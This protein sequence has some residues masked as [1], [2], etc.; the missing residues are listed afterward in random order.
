[1][2]K[3]VRAA[4]RQLDYMPADYGLCL[5]HISVTAQQHHLWLSTF[6]T[7]VRTTHTLSGPFRG[8]LILSV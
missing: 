7:L 6:P 3:R 5:R 4:R 1:M 2:H 8:Y